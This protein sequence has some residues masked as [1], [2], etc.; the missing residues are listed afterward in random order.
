LDRWG[1]VE[2]NGKE[3]SAFEGKKLNQLVGNIK[4]K[5]GR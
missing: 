1:V 3:K 5:K 2:L 4:G